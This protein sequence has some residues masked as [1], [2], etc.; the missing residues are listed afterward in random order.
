MRK[1]NR[2]KEIYDTVKWS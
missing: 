1:A 2:I